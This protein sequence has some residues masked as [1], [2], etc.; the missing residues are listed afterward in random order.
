[1]KKQNITVSNNK[2]Y[3]IIGMICILVFGIGIGFI[4]NGT[5]RVNNSTMSMAQCQQISNQIIN[6]AENNNPDFFI[7]QTLKDLNNLYE[8][9]CKNNNKRKNLLLASQMCSYAFFVSLA[10]FILVIMIMM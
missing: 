8:K 10:A 7:D 9:R 1:M 6:A 4:I 2:A 5:S 3:G